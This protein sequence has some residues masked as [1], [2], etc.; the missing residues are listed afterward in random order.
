MPRQCVVHLSLGMRMVG[1]SLDW[2]LT[3]HHQSSNSIITRLERFLGFFDA[4]TG[5]PNARVRLCARSPGRTRKKPQNF[6]R[7]SHGG[8]AGAKKRMHAA[9]RGNVAP[10][11]GRVHSPPNP[12]PCLLS[13]PPLPSPP[14]PLPRE[15]CGFGHGT[16]WPRSRSYPPL[17]SQIAAQHRQRVATLALAVGFHGSPLS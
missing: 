2:P 1:A 9:P 3:N 16:R 6:E 7:E 5:I 14:L 12:R 11:I 10:P 17:S 4:E 13:R 15:P 8:K